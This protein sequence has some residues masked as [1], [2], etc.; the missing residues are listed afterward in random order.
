MAEPPKDGTK[1]DG[2]R[3]AILMQ[4]TEGE[5]DDQTTARMLL[6]PCTRHALTSMPFIGSNL[7]ESCPLPG[8]MDFVDG[9]RSIAGKAE[10]G[11][12]AL[13]SRMLVTQAVALDA[14]FGEFARRSSLNMGSHLDAA[15]RY[16]RL[17]L[18][19]QSNSRATL[20]ALAKLHQPREQIVRH[21]HVNE[22][23]Q[24]IV[25]DQVNHYARG[26]GNAETD[27][28]SQ[29]AEAL[30]ECTA[31][32]CPDPAGRR[33]PVPGSEGAQAMPDARR[34]KSGRA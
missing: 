10:A 12:M 19:A 30:D 18:K 13:V 23:G 34:H 31:M 33:V 28:Q 27:K 22:G 14:I 3:N 1:P 7:S 8:A 29:A 15:E 25:A 4:Q 21:V 5:T 26:A 32:P 6:D 24:A 16:A 11:D 2:K 20:E 17:A 9:L